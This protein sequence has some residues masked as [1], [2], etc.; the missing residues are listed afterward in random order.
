MQPMRFLFVLTPQEVQRVYWA[1]FKKK[2]LKT[3][4]IQCGIFVALGVYFLITYLGA[5]TYKDGLALCLI[6]FLF[7]LFVAAAPVYQF[8]KKSRDIASQNTE[9]YIQLEQTAF[10]FGETGGAERRVDYG[11]AFY[12]LED[13]TQF[14]IVFADQSI[15]AL[16][17]RVM[18]AQQAQQVRQIFIT[19]QKLTQ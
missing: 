19:H 8:Y 18:G 7:A 3:R 9:R 10:L 6:S 15:F 16:P 17:K 14:Y 11:D 2:G 5:R 4:C 12:V 1:H 13:Q